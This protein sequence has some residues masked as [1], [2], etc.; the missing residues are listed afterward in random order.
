MSAS[1]FARSRVRKFLEARRFSERVQHGG[2]HPSSPSRV[3]RLFALRVIDD[4][5][6][7]VTNAVRRGNSNR[8]ER[9]AK[10]RRAGGSLDRWARA[11]FGKRF[12]TFSVSMT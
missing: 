4:T 11:R 10:L 6:W 5:P 9:S 12:R 3:S 8:A 1:S 2:M 7:M